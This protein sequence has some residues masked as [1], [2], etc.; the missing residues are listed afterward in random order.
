MKMFKRVCKISDLQED[1]LYRFDVEET[2]LLVVKFGGSVFVT[3]SICTHEEADL[4]LGMF[5]SGVVTCPL[6]RARFQVED[7]KVLSGPDGGPADEISKLRVYLTKIEDGE[8]FADLTQN[9]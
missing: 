7:G 6:H 1:E 9:D 4:S 8:V 5:D 2:P 3:N